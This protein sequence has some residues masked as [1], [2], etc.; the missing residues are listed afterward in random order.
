MEKSQLKKFRV[1]PNTKILVLNSPDDYKFPPEAK[2]IT[3]EKVEK[4]IAAVHL[5]IRNKKELEKNFKKVVTLLNEKTNL[6]LFYPKMS[7]NIKTDVN[8]DS[9]AKF[10]EN[11]PV[12]ISSLVSYDDTW[13]AFLIRKNKENERN[14]K[15]DKNLTKFLPYIDFKNR[16]VT[17]PEDFEK[18]LRKNKN[19]LQ[20]FDKLS[21]T[22]KKEYVLAILEAKKT[23]TRQRRIQKIIQ[24]LSN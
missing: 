11:F 21:F 4:N 3:V 10:L 13:S 17:L 15:T 1:Q 14:Q 18:E 23:E 24:M 6:W 22:H 9:I 20:K 19:A 16:V 7:S 12:K 5:F 8:S 2:S